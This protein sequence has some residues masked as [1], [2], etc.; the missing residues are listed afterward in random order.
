[1]TVT[2]TLSFFADAN[3]APR[4]LALSQWW[5]GTLL[6]DKKSWAVLGWWVSCSSGVEELSGVSVSVVGQLS[7]AQL[8]G[9]GRQRERGAQSHNL[10]IDETECEH[11]PAAS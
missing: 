4:T 9:P 6:S 5:P 10:F 2:V 11:Q 1:M 8:H 3:M 7:S